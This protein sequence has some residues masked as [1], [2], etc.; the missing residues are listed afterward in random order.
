MK[1]T[2]TDRAAIVADLETLRG[3]TSGGPTRSSLRSSLPASPTTKLVTRKGHHVKHAIWMTRLEAQGLSAARA[4][5]SLHVG[6][7]VSFPLTQRLA[8]NLL[9]ERCTRSLRDP[10]EAARLRAELLAVREER[11][12]ETKD[13]S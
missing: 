8:L 10:V 4:T 3:L 12:G 5:L 2:D 11:R 9:A 6:R 1:T 7:N 13:A